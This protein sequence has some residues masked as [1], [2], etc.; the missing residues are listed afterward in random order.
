[1]PYYRS[2][3]ACSTG[4]LA[5]FEHTITDLPAAVKSKTNFPKSVLI[6]TCLPAN[7]IQS[8]ADDN[9]VCWEAGALSYRSRCSRFRCQQNPAAAQVAHRW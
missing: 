2:T 4:I 7:Q 6:Q 8:E 1:M 5:A 9:L 3:Y